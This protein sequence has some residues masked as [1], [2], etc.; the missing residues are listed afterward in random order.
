MS[1][2]DFRGESRKT[3]TEDPD[4]RPSRR[5]IEILHQ[6]D[7]LLAISKPP[8]VWIDESPEEHATVIEQLD[9]LELL[10]GNEASPAYPLD[11][12]VSGLLILPRTSPA[13]QNLDEQ[14]RQGLLTLTCAVLVR[15][16]IMQDHG[17]IDLQLSHT[18]G[19]RMKIDGSGES[20]ATT[21]KV[22]DRFVGFA[23]VECRPRP[24]L[25]NQIRP[26]LEA[27]GLPLAVDPVYG[28]SRELMLSSFK[29]GYRP[30]HRHAERPLIDRV[31]M[32]VSSAE[33]RHPRRGD[34]VRWEC[35]PPKDFRAT[36]HQLNRFGRMP[37]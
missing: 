29:A 33:F 16:P 15:G 7:D 2:Y 12:A 1:R 11:P 24:P 35:P 17:Q 21:W 5:R 22:I 23:L 25:P 13:A 28:G 32:H 20:A 36:L 14:V 10:Q 27:A 6:D 26:L 8:G 34:P 19:G 31:S 3:Q 37:R 4:E 9:A 30:S 18:P